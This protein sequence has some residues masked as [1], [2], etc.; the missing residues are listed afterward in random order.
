[1]ISGHQSMQIEATAHATGLSY[2]RKFFHWFLE[3]PEVFAK[4]GFSC[5]LGNPPFLGGKKIST[6]YGKDF[7]NFILKK[8]YPIGSV[9]LVTF[10]FRRIYTIIQNEGFLSLIF[11]QYNFSRR[12][13][14]GWSQNHYR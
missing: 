4:G 14:V 7:L 3:F 9:D 12:C 13:K 2:E 1:M 5:V 10:F 11:H 6:A 8:Y